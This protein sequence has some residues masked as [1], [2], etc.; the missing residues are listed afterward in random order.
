MR[1]LHER[2][3]CPMRS[4]IIGGNELLSVTY[5]PS[6]VRTQDSVVTYFPDNQIKV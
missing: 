5:N 4:K 2:E 1:K 3:L 6:T